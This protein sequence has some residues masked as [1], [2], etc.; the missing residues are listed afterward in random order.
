MNN[1]LQNVLNEIKLEKDTNLLPENIK[2][3]VK[4]FDIVGTLEEGGTSKD[5]PVKLFKTQEEIQ[6]DT[7][8]KE[9]DLAVVYRSE[10]QNATVDSEFQTATF[11]DTVVLDNAITD[12]VEVRYR[13][14]DSSKMF[15]CMGSLDS[16]S[17]MMNCYSDSGEVRIEYTSSDGI[18][19]TRTDTTGNPVDF[20]TEIYYERPEMWNDAIGYFIQINESIFDGLFSYAREINKEYFKFVSDVVYENEVYSSVLEDI[21]APKLLKCIEAVFSETSKSTAIVLYNKLTKKFLSYSSSY[22]G[23][24]CYYN[25]GSMFIV[26]SKETYKVFELDVINGTIVQQNDFTPTEKIGSSSY[27]LCNLNNY[28]VCGIWANHVSTTQEDSCFITG[29]SVVAYDGSSVSSTNAKDINY[30]FGSPLGWIH[31][32][33]QLTLSNP[34]EILPGKVGYGK[35]GVVTADGSIYNNLDITKVLTDIHKLPESTI[36]SYKV[37]GPIDN[38]GINSTD[39]G[40]LMLIKN[41]DTYTGKG[42][43]TVDTNLRDSIRNL[44]DTDTYTVSKIIINKSYSYAVVFYYTDSSNVILGIVDVNNMSLI[45]SIPTNYHYMTEYNAGFIKD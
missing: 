24:P 34:N 39:I 16:S 28:A 6:A 22:F 12:Y 19:Y 18:T 40:K 23:T 44:I 11:P 7:T 8:A 9:G 2:K 13:A 33:S 38:T 30:S 27:K 1:E 21:H 45:S 29:N 25:R 32:P 41:T 14:V 43:I 31:A 10:V 42:I 4:I 26:S 17:F 20:G 5:V 15:D 3:D 37:Y 35:N 36:D